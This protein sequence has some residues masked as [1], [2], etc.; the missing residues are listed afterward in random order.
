M[1][2]VNNLEVSYGQIKALKGI[3][4]EVPDKKIITLIGA[5]GAGKTTTLRTLSGLNKV[6]K[7]S[8]IFKGEDITNLSA[9]DLVKKGIVHVP[10]GRRIFSTL[11]VMENLDMAAWNLKDKAEKEKRYQNVFEL[12]PRL[13]ERVKQLGGTLS[14][15]EQQML[16]VARALVT[17]GDLMLFDEPSMGLS[18]V[19]VEEI[20]DIILKINK[21]G[22]TILLVEQN[23]KK[24]L[25]ISD[26]AYVLEV[27]SIT[28]SGPSKEIAE[29]PKVKEAYLGV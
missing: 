1:L 21:Q 17:G 23:A 26:F 12:F 14:G 16:A 5:N 11:T 29:N 13:K 22:T 2:T 4:F 25:E 28:F 6:N 8:I 20:F 24:A 10:E 27:G 19:L 3:S 7:G 15:G 18:P 9:H